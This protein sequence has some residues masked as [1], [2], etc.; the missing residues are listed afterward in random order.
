[1]GHLSF[2]LFPKHLWH[3]WKTEFSNITMG[4]KTPQP[5]THNYQ[6]GPNGALLIQSSFNIASKTVAACIQL[7][8][9]YNEKN[10][11]GIIV[12]GVRM[13]EQK[14]WSGDTEMYER[15]P[16]RCCLRGQEILSN[17][18]GKY[19]NV[20]LIWDS[21]T[22]REDRTSFLCKLKVGRQPKTHEESPKIWPNSS[23]CCSLQ[24]CRNTS[25]PALPTLRL[26]RYTNS[27]NN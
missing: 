2:Q 8:F 5:L 13:E 24:A 25:P 10:I 23:F 21:Q 7:K 3:W 22:S 14:K 18:S 12:V 9:N 17:W 15:K 26:S 6:W 1:M 4:C 19:K 27:T 11:V 16:K 20:Q